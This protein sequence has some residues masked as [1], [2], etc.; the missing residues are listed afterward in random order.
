MENNTA[1]QSKTLKQP[2]KEWLSKEIEARTRAE[3]NPEEWKAQEQ[4]RQEYESSI[5]DPKHKSLAM[6]KAG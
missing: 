4:R 1:D 6:N 2:W 5:K 3:E